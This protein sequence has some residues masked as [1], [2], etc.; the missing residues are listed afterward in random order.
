[1][2]SGKRD[3]KGEK[4]KNGGRVERK[5]KTRKMGAITVER[6]SKKERGKSQS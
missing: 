3:K 2:K 6:R 1:M 5:Q 4:A